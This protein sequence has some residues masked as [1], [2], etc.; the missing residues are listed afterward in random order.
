M[1]FIRLGGRG[2]FF[3]LDLRFKKVSRLSC[4]GLT[5]PEDDFMDKVF[6]AC[7]DCAGWIRCCGTS[8]S[9]VAGLVLASMFVFSKEGKLVDNC[10]GTTGACPCFPEL[11]LDSSE[12]VLARLLGVLG[13]QTLLGA[14]A[15][16]LGSTDPR[17]R[18][19]VGAGGE[20]VKLARSGTSLSQ[21]ESLV[22]LLLGTP[23]L[24]LERDL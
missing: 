23:G 13:A 4:R 22:L 2:A 10:C 11:R 21:R 24:L 1:L 3:R 5:L 12:R 19:L 6:L 9:I 16:G 14:T 20:A 17:L 15:P 7:D 18:L 8:S